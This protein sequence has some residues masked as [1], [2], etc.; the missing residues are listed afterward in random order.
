MATNN[1]ICISR[2]PDPGAGHGFNV[3]LQ[4]IEE[5]EVMP[6]AL[7]WIDGLPADAYIAPPSAMIVLSTQKRYMFGQDGQ[8]YE[9]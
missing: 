3:V 8:W 2:Y 6:T 9:I 4:A 5:P 7:D 1:I